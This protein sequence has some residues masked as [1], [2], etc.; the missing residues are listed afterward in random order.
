MIEVLEG[1]YNNY[2]AVGT[3]AIDGIL[4]LSRIKYIASSK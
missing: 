4:L 2:L 1:L 3:L